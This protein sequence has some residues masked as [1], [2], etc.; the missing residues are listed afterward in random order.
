MTCKLIYC[1][2]VN[3]KQ[4]SIGLYKKKEIPKI[5]NLNIDIICHQNV[6]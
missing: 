2:N 1:C 6:V 4:I 5:S 3:H